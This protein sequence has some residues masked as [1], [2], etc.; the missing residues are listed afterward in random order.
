VRKVVAVSSAKGGVGKSTVAG[1]SCLKFRGGGDS[2]IMYPKPSPGS[3]VCR[4]F[5]DVPSWTSIG[6]GL[7]YAYEDGLMFCTSSWLSTG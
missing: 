3:V 4:V 6:G 5:C 1:R 2:C 7:F